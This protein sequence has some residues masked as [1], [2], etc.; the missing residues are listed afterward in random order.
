[1][2][3]I[4]R[5]YRVEQLLTYS[6]LS[7]LLETPSKHSVLLPLQQARMCREENKNSLTFDDSIDWFSE[8]Y[9]GRDEGIRSRGGFL[10]QTIANRKCECIAKLDTTIANL[11]FENIM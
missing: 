1:M 2:V 11:R 8:T 5:S 7:D 4:V 10:H 9:L 6:D 3:Y